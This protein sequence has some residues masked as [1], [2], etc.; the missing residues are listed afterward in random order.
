MTSESSKNV[1]THWKRSI[2]TVQQRLHHSTIYVTSISTKRVRQCCTLSQ[3][4]S[5]VTSELLLNQIR[6]EHTISR[7][8]KQQTQSLLAE[9]FMPCANDTS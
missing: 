2:A 9:D 3:N 4:C 7:E 8:G 5:V 1:L 6:W